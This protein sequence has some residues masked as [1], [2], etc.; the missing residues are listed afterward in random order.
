MNYSNFLVILDYQLSEPIG[1]PLSRKRGTRRICINSQWCQPVK[2][3]KR[4][5]PRNSRV[6]RRTSGVSSSSS[7]LRNA[8]R[9]FRRSRL[10]L[11]IS[12]GSRMTENLIIL[13]LKLKQWPQVDQDSVLDRSQKILLNYHNLGQGLNPERKRRTSYS[14][15]NP[16]RMNE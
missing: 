16:K 1:S 2:H 12:P 14:M 13:P 15:T 7:P 5:P 4:Y 11:L 10:W 6:W 3:W 8:Y 9:R